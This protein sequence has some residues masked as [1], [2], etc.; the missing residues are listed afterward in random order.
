MEMTRP[1]L[2][3]PAAAYSIQDLAPRLGVS[4]RTLRFYEERGLIESSRGRGGARH[5]DQGTADRVEQIV[6]LRRHGLSLGQIQ[7]AVRADDIGALLGVLRALRANR[8]EQIGKLDD[9]LARLEKGG[10]AK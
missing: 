8:V 5:Y 9:L 7:Q 6:T 2:Q 1:V 3:A 10:A 4:A